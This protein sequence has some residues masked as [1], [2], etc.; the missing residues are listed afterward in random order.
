VEGII[1]EIGGKNKPLKQ[2]QTFGNQAFL[3]KEDE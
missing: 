2:I 1:R 3:V